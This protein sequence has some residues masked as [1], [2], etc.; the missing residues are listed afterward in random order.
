M[1]KI[2]E[3]PTFTHTVKVKVPID[4]GYRDETCKATYRVISP[5]LSDTYDLKTTD[6]S[7]EFLRAVLMKMDDIADAQGQPLEW[8]DEVRDQVLK[9]PYARAALAGAYFGALNGAKKGN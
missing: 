1:F 3:E 5:E 6:G 8:S 2:V 7:T 4:G 9:L